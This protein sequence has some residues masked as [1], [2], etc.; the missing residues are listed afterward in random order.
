MQNI[1]FKAELREI[2]FARAA[3][4]RLGAHK[5]GRIEQ[6][7][8]YFRVLTGRLKRRVAITD[9]EPE[10]AEVIQYDRRDRT[11][12]K[13]S[14]F[15]I[16]TED[17]ARE[18][19]GELPLPIWCEVRK[20]REVWMWGGVRVHLDEV[21]DLGRFIEFEAL[22]T[23]RQHV[24]RC[25]ELIAELRRALGPAVGEP[26]STGYADMLAGGTRVG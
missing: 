11:Q 16:Y 12:P 18:R 6:V 21:E 13:M 15:T 2:G 3:L 19:F 10:P 24:R 20:K 4:R 26:I 8:T 7:D 1:E 14:R 9:G 23:P 17:E 22:V 5:V 25:H